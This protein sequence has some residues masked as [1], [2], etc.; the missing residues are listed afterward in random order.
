VAPT[1]TETQTEVVV[2]VD[3]DLDLATAPNWCA[4]IENTFR[5]PG[6]RV[7]VDLSRVTFCDSTG[8]RALLGVVREAQVHGVPLRIVLP[9]Q[10][11]PQR[12]FELAGALEFLPLAH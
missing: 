7:L 12:A 11:A 3:G 8:M 5:T 9:E 1:N 6:A 4:R 10:A 2:E